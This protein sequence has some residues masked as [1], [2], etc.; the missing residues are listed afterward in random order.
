[1]NNVSGVA[2]VAGAAPGDCADDLV[3]ADRVALVAARLPAP[4]AVHDTADVFSLLGDP[5]RLTLLLGLL[6]GELCVH[7][8]AALTGQSDSA[9]SHALKLLRAHRVVATRRAGRRIYYRLEDPHVRMLLDLAIAHT[10]HSEVTHP[11]KEGEGR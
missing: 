11:E 5:T 2:S 10:E 6:D 9:T 4:E 7:D 3:D 1:M 8:L